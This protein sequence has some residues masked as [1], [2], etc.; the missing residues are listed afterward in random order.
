M[1]DVIHTGDVLSI[2]L[3]E[4]TNIKPNY[5]LSVPIVYEDEDVIVYNKP[6]FMPVHPSKGHLD[7]TLA[8]VFCAHMNNL[9]I[10]AAFHPINRLDR[11]TSGLC[12]VAKNSLSTSIL[13]KALEK[14]YTAVVCGNVSPKVG[15]IDAPITRLCGSIIK[16]CIAK[17]G[18]HAIT[19][20]KVESENTKYSLVRVNLETG[21]THQIRVHFSHI[22]NPLAGDS[23]YGGDMTDINRQALCCNM[24][25]FIHPITNICINLCID[26][27]ED[28][29]KL[30]QNE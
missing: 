19:N 23:M 4:D 16:R 3:R 10:K 7:D 11:D 26:M 24:V 20:Y 15:K 21:R 27:Q 5:E 12:V 13:S 6:P 30:M 8:N 29:H 17:D 2:N 18:Q 14:Q 22:G 28:M 25:R 9:G 1:I